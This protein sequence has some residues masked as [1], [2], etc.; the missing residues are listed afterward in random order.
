MSILSG[1][2]KIK[3]Y[4]ANDAGNHQ[5]VSEWTSASTV[6][7]TNGN[8]AE[9]EIGEIKSDI[10]N[11]QDLGLIIKNGVVYDRWEEK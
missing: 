8:T 11:L 7:M 2:K 10:S 3:K 1:F 6:E 9:T 5:L 4:E